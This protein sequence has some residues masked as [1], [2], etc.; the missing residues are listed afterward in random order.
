MKR[1]AF[2]AVVAAL[3]LVIAPAVAGVASATAESS[4]QILMFSKG[5]YTDPYEEDLDMATALESI[6]TVTVFD[7]GDSSVAAWTAALVGKDAVVFPEG[8]VYGLTDCVESTWDPEAEGGGGDWVDGDPE[9]CPM[10]T[11]AAAYVKTWISAGRTALGTGAYDHQSFIDYLTGQEYS[12]D[13]DEVDAGWNLQVEADGAPD[14]LPNM[15]YSGGIAT[16]GEWSTEEKA[17]VTAIYLDESGENLGVGSFPVGR[18]SF[19]YYAYDWYPDDDDRESGK[20][21]L[22]EDALRLGATNILS[23]IE[24]APSIG[25]DIVLDLAVGDVVAGAAVEATGS[26]MK[27]DSPWNLVL[28]S[29]PVTLD[30]GLV[31]GA[32]SVTVSATIPDGLSVGWHS[33]T[34]T[35][36]AAD[37][38]TYERVVR[39]EIG[40]DG[41]LASEIE[42]LDV[43]EA[44]ALADPTLAATGA[45]AALPFGLAVLALLAGATLVVVRRKR[46]NA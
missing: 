20:A 28:R 46:A 3:A 32:G 15:N 35:G 17:S 12:W 26:G 34:L 45:E 1:Q 44:E 40:A 18:G 8:T 10:S 21:Q 36:T 4:A 42:V 31:G 24:K 39:F 30:F 16:Y 37:G 14:V 11:E 25:L 33:L 43:A 13:D 23:P 6:G 22:W 19:M 9:P 27:A 2:A 7:G 29:T 41:T 38:T 5:G